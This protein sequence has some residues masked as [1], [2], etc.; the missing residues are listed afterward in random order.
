MKIDFGR[1]RWR[2]RNNVGNYFIPID[3]FD[4][5]ARGEFGFHVFE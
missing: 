1:P 4:F 2:D 3:E 5:L